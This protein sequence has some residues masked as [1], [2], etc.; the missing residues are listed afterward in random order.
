MKK[1]ANLASMLFVAAAIGVW[2][3]QRAAQN[4][5]LAELLA[6]AITGAIP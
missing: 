6:Q 3:C 5:R 4:G 2:A 1:P